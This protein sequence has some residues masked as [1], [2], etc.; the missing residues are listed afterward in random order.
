[1]TTSL[2]IVG[3]IMLGAAAVGIR[4]LARWAHR[5]PDLAWRST[6]V[7]FTTGRDYLQAQGIANSLEARK[8]TARG[9]RY[10]PSAPPAART[11][12]V[13]ATPRRLAEVVSLRRRQA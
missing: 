4:M 12:A 6:G 13:A 10:Q 11:A 3:G 1:M 2:L 8:H 9:R 5:A 7:R